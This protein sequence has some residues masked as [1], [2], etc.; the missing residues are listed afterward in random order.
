L[1]IH[2]GLLGKISGRRNLIIA[3]Q[4]A[5]LPVGGFFES[6]P[7][8]TGAPSVHRGDHIAQGGK[9]LKPQIVLTTVNN[10]GAAANYLNM[11]E[12]DSVT[13]TGTAPNGYT[14]D[15][16]IKDPNGNFDKSKRNFC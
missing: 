15:L 14:V 16:I 11:T 10:T 12:D 2:P 7:S 5:Q 4:F 6:R 1:G 13:I 3:F 9:V 8:V